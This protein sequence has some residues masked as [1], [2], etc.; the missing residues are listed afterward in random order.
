MN[1]KSG[2]K[3]YPG[4]RFTA[5]MIMNTREFPG[6]RKNVFFVSLAL[7]WWL[8]TVSLCS[9]AAFNNLSFNSR[10]GQVTIEVGFDSAISYTL[11]TENEGR[12]LIL[13]VPG[14]TYSKETTDRIKLP[15]NSI[16]SG[17]SA[18]QAGDMIE[19]VFRLTGS[20]SYSHTYAK[21]SA[22][23]IEVFGAR[24]PEPAVKTPTAA[25]SPAVSASHLAKGIELFTNGR[26]DDALTEFN[27]EVNRNP[28]SPLSYYYAAH[29]RL[30][31]KQNDR[32]EENLLAALRDSSTF[33]DAI[34]L[35][36]YTRLKN[37]KTNQAL[38][39]WRTFVASV[40]PLKD[41]KTITVESIMLPEEYRFQLAQERE[42]ELAEGKRLREAR[43]TH[44][45]SLAASA[46]ATAVTT[47]PDTTVAGAG[48][49]GQG[50][51]A[52]A[53]DFE[54]RFNKDLR[55]GVYGL[56]AAAVLLLGLITWAVIWIRRRAKSKIDLTFTAEI[57]RLLDER[58]GRSEEFEENEEA[59]LREYRSITSEIEM[60]S[61][62][63]RE[64]DHKEAEP[65][66]PAATPAEEPVEEPYEAPARLP[67]FES[68]SD[69][70]TEEVKALVTRMYREGRGIAEIARAADLTQTEVELIVAVRARRMDQL[71]QEVA[72][73]EEDFMD[74]SQLNHAIYE[75]RSEGGSPR[76]I[77]RKL[78]ISTSEVNMALTMKNMRKTRKNN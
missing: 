39:D 37:G 13:R 69:A 36:A 15:A 47:V 7:L 78:G 14:A 40:E 58:A 23:R 54:A 34:G 33:S 17:W 6:C 16:L 43:K 29:I 45:D 72:S 32:A 76:D 66:E 8:A 77:A 9:A 2:K 35:L 41:K 73:E 31:K 20:Y 70:I 61:E 46:Q 26:L 62:S 19:V 18:R 24:N 30:R 11:R 27:A 49:T 44:A 56:F 1:K 64:T 55:Y 63:P 10:E 57:E 60:V 5:P 53:A 4:E 3:D 68:R 71:V 12:S 67:S 28:E 51:T 48:E 42:K 22:V 38:A 59:A 74:S 21:P 52:P 65:V 50:G 25:V 75:L